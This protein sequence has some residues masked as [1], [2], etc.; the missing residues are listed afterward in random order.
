M[1][2]TQA[3]LRFK[4]PFTAS[5]RQRLRRRVPYA[6]A[7]VKAST[8]SSTT[9][10]TSVLSSPSPITRMTGSVPDGRTINRPPPPS[11][12]SA[13]AIAERTSAFSSR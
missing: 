12:R 13:L 6:A 11:L 1:R 4:K 8:T 2:S 9:D 5:Q 7:C 10:S 3:E